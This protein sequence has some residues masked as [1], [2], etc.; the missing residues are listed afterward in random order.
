MSYLRDVLAVLD[1]DAFVTEC[2][3]WIQATLNF[4]RAVFSS[5]GCH[6]TK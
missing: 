1:H 5:Q 6:V 2:V 4:Y 3:C